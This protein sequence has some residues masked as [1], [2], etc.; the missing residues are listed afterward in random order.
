MVSIDTAIAISFGLISAI[1]SLIS[2]LI[3]YLTLRAMPSEKNKDHIAPPKNA[4]TFH[5]K[6]KYFLAQ[7]DDKWE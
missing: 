3:A 6:H 1:I 2:M 4:M 7:G 5:H